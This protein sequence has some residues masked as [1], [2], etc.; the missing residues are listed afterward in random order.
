MGRHLHAVVAVSTHAPLAGS[1][2]AVGEIN[3][4]ST[5]FQ[6]T[7]PLRGATALL[8]VPP[9]GVNVSTHAPLAGSDAHS[10]L[11]RRF[12]GCFNPRSPCG[13]R[14]RS[15]RATSARSCFNPRSPCG[16]RRSSCATRLRSTSFNPRSPCGERLGRFL[17][18]HHHRLVST[19]APLAG[20]DKLGK[21]TMPVE[22]VF[23]PTLPLRGAT[24]PPLWASWTGTVST[25]APLAG[26]D[27]LSAP[28]V[29]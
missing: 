29:C 27:G 14:R 23:Q 4:R 16:E 17:D 8:G 19:H 22:I 28:V 1:D 13:E 21:I 10:H 5:V 26:S 3:S 18:L 12:Q 24:A 6:P 11:H 20:S 25:H 9:G 7:L 2:M 15:R